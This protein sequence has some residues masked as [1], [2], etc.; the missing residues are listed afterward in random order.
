M[1]GIHRLPVTSPHKGQWRGALIC[2]VCAWPNGWEN[3]RNAGDLRSHF[4]HCD[5]IVNAFVFVSSLLVIKPMNWIQHLNICFSSLEYILL[6]LFLIV[7]VVMWFS[8]IIICSFEKMLWTDL[9][10]VRHVK[11]TSTRHKELYGFAVVCYVVVIFSHTLSREYRVAGYRYSLLLFTCEDRLCANMHVQWQSS[12]MTLQYQYLAFGWRHRSIMVTS[13]RH[14]SE[15]T[16]LGN[17]GEMSARL[18]FLV[19][20]CIHY[21]IERV[22]IK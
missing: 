7:F 14:K 16:A 17:N 13:Q 22:R 8:M 3:N 15:K 20:L 11:H 6:N 10:F 12:N 19:D 4:A 18:W 1:G 5:V 9:W 2:L 21:I